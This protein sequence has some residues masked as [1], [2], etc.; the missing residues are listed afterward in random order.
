METL[1]V[2]PLKSEVPLAALE[3]RV[4]TLLAVR[5]KV[6]I[7]IGAALIPLKKRVKKEVGHWEEYFESKFGD[8]LSIR[9]AQRWMHRARKAENVNLT[10]LPAEDPQARQV[11]AA[12][13]KAKA[14]V[15]FRLNIP[16]HLQTQQQKDTIT[17]LL[18]SPNWLKAQEDVIKVLLEWRPNNE[19]LVTGPRPQNNGCGPGR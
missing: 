12:N 8:Q 3:A 9:S 18:K 19:N 16:L 7:Q 2:V 1:E 10:F 15:G 4:F 17:K 11:R 6:K 13:E 5:A 14:V